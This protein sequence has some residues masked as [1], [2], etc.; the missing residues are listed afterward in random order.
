ML[1]KRK[2]TILLLLFTSS[3]ISAQTEDTEDHGETENL[4][5]HGE[6]KNL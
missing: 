1:E 6:Y 5:F 3:I 4:I 2:F